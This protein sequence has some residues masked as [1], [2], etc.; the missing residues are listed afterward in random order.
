MISRTDSITTISSI[1]TATFAA[2]AGAG[3]QPQIFG[4]LAAISHAVNG[5]YTNKR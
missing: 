5:Y 4:L 3:V 2:L 1:S